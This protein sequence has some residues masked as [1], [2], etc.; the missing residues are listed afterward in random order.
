MLY[1]VV[2]EDVENDDSIAGIVECSI[3]SHSKAE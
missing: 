2:E 3:V 1:A